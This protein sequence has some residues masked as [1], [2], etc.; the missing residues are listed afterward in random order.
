VE[1][2]TFIRR[3]SNLEGGAERANYAMFLTELCGVLGVDPPNTAG[4]DRAANDYVFERAVKPRLSE[5][6]TTPKRIDLYKKNAFILEAKQSRLPGKKNEIPGQTSLFEEASEAPARRTTVRGWDVMMQNARKQAEGYV[7]DPFAFPDLDEPIRGKLGALGEE[8]DATRKLVLADHPDLTLT[9]L[10]NLLEKVKVGAALTSAEEDAKQRGRVLILKELH[11]Q[12][13]ALTAQAYGWPAD[14]TDEQILERLVSLNAERAKEEATGHVRWL[15]PDYQIP[16]FAKGAVAKTGEL[17]LGATVVALDKGLPPWPS[18][19][20]EH[21][22]AIEA[23]LSNAGRPMD[24]AELSRAFKN[25]GKKIEQ[26]IVQSLTNLA[27]YGRVTALADG[28]FA[29]RRV[30]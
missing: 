13:D 2:E 17:D 30:A 19:R 4:G 24:A 15:R 12:I 9:G 20:D 3:W 23:M 16:R 11:E 10:Y 27:L 7:F 29:A 26:R 28:K 22:L 5:A 1:V 6:S 21:P 18:N 8:L 25:G 14:L